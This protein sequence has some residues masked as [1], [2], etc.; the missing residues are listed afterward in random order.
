MRVGRGQVSLPFLSLSLR[1]A[2]HPAPSPPPSHPGRDALSL[3]YT[4]RRP[5][6]RG[7]RSDPAPRGHT[8]FISIAALSLAACQRGDRPRGCRRVCDRRAF[9]KLSLSPTQRVCAEPQAQ[10]NAARPRRPPGQGAGQCLGRW[11]PRLVRVDARRRRRRE[12]GALGPIA[13]AIAAPAPRSSAPDAFRSPPLAAQAQTDARPAPFSYT[14]PGRNHLY[15][16]G[17]QRARRA[18]RG[19]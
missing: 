7:V 9:P 1:L 3:M 2:L 11:R 16:P 10:R 8:P 13:P 19:S 18:A 5:E 17:E 12:W 6:G 15:V 14:P 4:A